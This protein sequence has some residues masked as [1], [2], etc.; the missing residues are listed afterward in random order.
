MSDATYR[1]IELTGTSSVGV[2]EAMQ[3]EI[4]RAHV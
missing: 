1:I 2:T 3:N 4:G